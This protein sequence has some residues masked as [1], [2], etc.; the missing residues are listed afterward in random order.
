[1]VIDDASGKWLEEEN[2]FALNAVLILITS[3]FIRLF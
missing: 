2:T 1:M 3:A